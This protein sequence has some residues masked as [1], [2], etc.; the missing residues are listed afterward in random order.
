MMQ[1]CK[2]IN[3]LQNILKFHDDKFRS[4]IAF[5]GEAKFKTTMPDN[6]VR[7][8]EYYINYILKHKNIVLN[9]NEVKESV[10]KIKY[11]RLSNAEH[12]K[13]MDKL[14]AKYG[15]D[16]K[17]KAPVCPGCKKKMIMRTAK[18]GQYRGRKFWGCVNYPKCRFT[19]N[20]KKEKTDKTKRAEKAFNT[21]FG[22]YR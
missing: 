19:V 14:K 3:V 15:D 10:E 17:N 21:F 9:R 11:H 5:S 13:Y 22:M 8:G 6:V 12:Q 2:H 1:N 16:E 4:L 18:K 20:V 7:G